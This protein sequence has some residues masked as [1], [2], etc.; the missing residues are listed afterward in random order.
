MALPDFGI[1]VRGWR[2]AAGMTQAGLG[3]AI[4]VVQEQVSR[5]ENGDR[6][7]TAAQLARMCDVLKLDA[8]ARLEALRLLALA[9][10]PTD[11]EDPAQAAG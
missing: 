4:G 8:D 11:D 9:P 2:R 6:A 5:I 3:L 7:V 10:T 1:A